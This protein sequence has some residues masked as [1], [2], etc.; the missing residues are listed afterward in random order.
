MELI[1]TIKF[2]SSKILY[3]MNAML[4]LLIYQYNLILGIDT[5]RVLFD[6]KNKAFVYDVKLKSRRKILKNITEDIVDQNI[7]DSF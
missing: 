2:S 4:I 6:S 1:F 3:Q 5:Y 7:K